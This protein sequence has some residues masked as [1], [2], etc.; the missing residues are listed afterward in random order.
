MFVSHADR[1]QHIHTVLVFSHAYKPALADALVFR[2]TAD[3][4]WPVRLDIPQGVEAYVQ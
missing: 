4:G 2:H 1:G 3:E